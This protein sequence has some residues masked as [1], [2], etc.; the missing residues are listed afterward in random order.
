MMYTSVTIILSIM[1]MSIIEITALAPQIS[2][3]GSDARVTA[4]A[5]MMAPPPP[6][7]N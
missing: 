5:H 1:I 6:A 7:K 4:G 3:R 2:H